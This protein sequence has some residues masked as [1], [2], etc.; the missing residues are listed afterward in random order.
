MDSRCYDGKLEL[1]ENEKRISL[2]GAGLVGTYL[3]ALLLV[4]VFSGGLAVL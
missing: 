3:A 1:P 4:A 2:K